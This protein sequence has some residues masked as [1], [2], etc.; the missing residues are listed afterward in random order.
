MRDKSDEFDPSSTV[1][2]IEKQSAA[3]KAYAHSRFVVNL[4]DKAPTRVVLASVQN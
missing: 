2:A 4:E 1:N 3:E